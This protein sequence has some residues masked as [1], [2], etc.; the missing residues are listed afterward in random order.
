MV[1]PTDDQLYDLW[2]TGGNPARRDLNLDLLD[3][4]WLPMLQVLKALGEKSSNNAKRYLSVNSDCPR[5]F[6]RVGVGATLGVEDR[7]CKMREGLLS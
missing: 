6:W 4:A 5:K 2:F 1:L 7:D 3:D